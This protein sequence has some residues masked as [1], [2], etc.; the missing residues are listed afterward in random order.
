MIYDLYYFP[1]PC[2]GNVFFLSGTKMYIQNKS[3]AFDK[4]WHLL[5]LIPNF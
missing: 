1:V 5:S 4:T 3:S 2:S